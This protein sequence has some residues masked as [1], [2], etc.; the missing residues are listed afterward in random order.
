[1]TTPAAASNRRS[2]ARQPTP[3]RVPYSRTRGAQVPWRWPA[4]IRWT[5]LF[6]GLLRASVHLSWRGS[7]SSML[8]SLLRR[9][10]G[11][12]RGMLRP[13]RRH[14]LRLGRRG[15]KWHSDMDKCFMS[16]LGLDEKKRMR[17][18]DRVVRR[19]SDRGGRAGIAFA[20]GA[21]LATRSALSKGTSLFLPLC[22]TEAE[23][24]T[25][26]SALSP[27]FPVAHFPIGWTAETGG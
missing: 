19:C 9:A 25:F 2:Q 6:L 20:G 1:M 15:H 3:N 10:S 7:K 17:T 21:L 16:C 4:Q 18:G 24:I 14:L 12:V 26:P 23:H 13:G 5:A 8:F 27:Y 22:S 11:L